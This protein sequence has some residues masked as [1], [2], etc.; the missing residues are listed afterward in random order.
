[1]SG[2]K[3]VVLFADNSG[4]KLA[5]NADNSLCSVAVPQFGRTR[6]LPIAI[7]DGSESIEN[8]SLVRTD[9]DVGSSRNRDRPLR[10]V[11]QSETR[12]AQYR[13]LFLKT[14]RIGKDQCCGR[15]E[16]EKFEIA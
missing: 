1:M 6:R 12:H 4:V 15:F 10:V 3:K 14:A 16:I 7:H 5:N 9:H 8:A 11:A 2:A 13:S